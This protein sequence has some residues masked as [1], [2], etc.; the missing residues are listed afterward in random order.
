[1]LWARALIRLAA[2]PDDARLAAGLL[3][4]P[5]N[6]L[7]VD[8]EMRWS[9]AIRWAALGMEGADERLASEK[10]RDPSDRG[11]RSALTAEASRPLAAAKEEVWERLHN[12]G[13][14][15]LQ[16]A[17]AAAAGFWRRTQ[18]ALVEPYVP[19][20]F[21]GLPALFESWEAE[22]AR[23]YYRTFFPDYRV[24]SSTRDAVGKLLARLNLGPMLRRLLI[25][26]DDDLL[27]AIEARELAA[28]P[29]D[30]EHPTEP[31]DRES[32]ISGDAAGG[33][34]GGRGE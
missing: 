22:A 31:P 25:E 19:R 29:P 21:D 26:T 30:G 18:R 9:V 2:T 12:H 15:S 4:V 32:P 33:V 5:P 14:D 1:V 24:E 3:D 7:A 17:M 11:Q 27:R 8:Q 13:Y 20:L 16:L 23:A 10:A 28:A 34:E 6:G